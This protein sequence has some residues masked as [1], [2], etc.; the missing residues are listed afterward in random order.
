MNRAKRLIKRLLR[1]CGICHGT[2]TRE[3]GTD[4]VECPACKGKG[5]I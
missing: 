5:M 3:T 1:A 4:T 2:G